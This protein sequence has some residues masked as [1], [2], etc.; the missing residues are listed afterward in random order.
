MDAVGFSMGTKGYIS[1]GYSSSG[2]YSDLWEWDQASNIWTQKTD[3][4]GGTLEG[5][6]AFA[7]GTKAYILAVYNGNFYEWDQATDTWTSKA[8]FPGLYRE[9]AFAFAIGTKGY[10]GGGYSSGFH[11]LSDFWE[12][13]QTNDS[14]TQKASYP[15]ERDECATFVISNVGFVC[16]GHNNYTGYSTNIS[17]KYN[18]A[19]NSWSSVSMTGFGGQVG[20]CVGFAIGNR[21]Y[22][23]IGYDDPGNDLKLFYEYSGPAGVEDINGKDYVMINP[24]PMQITSEICVDEQILKSNGSMTFRLYNISGE[25]VLSKQIVEP[26]TNIDRGSLAKGVYLYRIYNRKEEALGSGKLVIE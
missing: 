19:T 20:R 2:S 21:G 6:T 13:D 8:T 10:I 26:K 5:A 17:Y 9:T 4:P 1:T 7:I 22:V 23:G 12:Y 3:Y 25:E 11:S 14:W 18:Q 15:V 16:T 24:N